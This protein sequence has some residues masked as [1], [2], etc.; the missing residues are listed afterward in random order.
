M[1]F[2]EGGCINCGKPRITIEEQKLGFNVAQRN[3]YVA[4]DTTS[5]LVLGLCGECFEK[6]D[7]EFDLN[8]I[9]KNMLDSEKKAAELKLAQFEPMEIRSIRKRK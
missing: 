4:N 9:K 6:P 2:F 1:L 5:E 8:H 3:I 7:K